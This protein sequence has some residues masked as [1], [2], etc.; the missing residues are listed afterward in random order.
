[1]YINQ[2]SVYFVPVQVCL[3]SAIK[4]NAVASQNTNITV[5]FSLPS[6]FLRYLYAL[7]MHEK[8]GKGGK[9][10]S[11]KES[12]SSWTNQRRKRNLDERSSE[13]RERSSVVEKPPAP[14]MSKVVV[15]EEDPE[16]VERLEVMSQ[17]DAKSEVSDQDSS[18]QVSIK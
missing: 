6:P 13:E 12:P 2:D 18:S 10:S 9:Q 4:S 15:K 5:I 11:V 7:E 1:M 17:N 14:K 16:E 8:G 3:L